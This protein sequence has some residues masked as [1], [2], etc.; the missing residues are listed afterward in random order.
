[1]TIGIKHFDIEFD[2]NINQESFDNYIYNLSDCAHRSIHNNGNYLK[3]LD[4][5]KLIEQSNKKIPINLYEKFVYDI[6]RDYCLKL[7]L[8]MEDIHVEFWMK[9]H[10]QDINLSKDVFLHRDCD[11][12]ERKNNNNRIKRTPLLSIVN[13][14]STFYTC[15]TVIT[16]IDE[17]E[18]EDEAKLNSNITILSFPKKYKSI[19]FDGGRYFHGSIPIFFDKKFIDSDMRTLLVINLWL[20][21]PPQNIEFFDMDKHFSTDLHM[22]CDSIENSLFKL[23]ENRNVIKYLHDESYQSIKLNQSLCVSNNDVFLYYENEIIKYIN[24]FSI[25]VFTKLGNVDELVDSSQENSNY[26]LQPLKETHKKTMATIEENLEFYEK[27]ITTKQLVNINEDKFIQ[28]FTHSNVFTKDICDWIIYESE[29]FATIHGWTLNRHDA[30]PTTDIPIQNIRS[31]FKFI[32]TSF[33]DNIKEKIITDY[34]ITNDKI[35]DVNDMFIVKYIAD[36]VH[37]DSLEM[38]YD[39]SLFSASILLN[40]KSDFDGGGT[41]YEDGITS[42]INKGDMIIHTK[43]H[44]HSGLKITRGIRYI[45]VFFINVRD[46]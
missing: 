43:R 17:D 22:Y 39:A 34:C 30:Y 35:F 42:H 1:M 37:Q 45:L 18:D 14:L 9:T 26:I 27:I 40:E 46:N 24:E 8:K 6:A 36:G 4:V 11:E 19:S 28:R 41:Y 16:D 10:K 33:F 25:F 23:T 38:H 5:K 31:V 32:V 3:L 21:E 12:Q 20:N 29:L 15:P 13:Y 44:K 7:N 2:E